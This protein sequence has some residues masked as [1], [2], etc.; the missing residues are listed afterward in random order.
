MTGPLIIIAALSLCWHVLLTRWVVKAGHRALDRL[1]TL[2]QQI[3]NLKRIE[4]HV[5]IM[6]VGINKLGDLDRER[7]TDLTLIRILRNFSN[8]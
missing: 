3:E 2:D 5:A 6:Q 4:S 1:P 8:N 7:A